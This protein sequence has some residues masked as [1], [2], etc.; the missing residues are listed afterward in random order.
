MAQ[1]SQLIFPRL[2]LEILYSQVNPDT[3]NIQGK[4]CRDDP[5]W[6]TDDNYMCKD[7]SI[8][9][10]TC[11]DVGKGQ[12]GSQTAEEACPVA[13]NT[14][15]KDVRIKRDFTKMYRRLPSPIKDA[16]E[17]N[18]SMILKDPEWAMGS[19]ITDV[20]RDPYLTDMIEELEDKVD[21]LRH[22]MSGLKCLCSDISGKDKTRKGQAASLAPIRCGNVSEQMEWDGVE[23]W[24]NVQS[25]DTDVRY[26][27]KCKKGKYQ[28]ANSFLKGKELV[29]NC[30][31]QTWEYRDE[32]HRDKPFVALDLKKYPDV[33]KCLGDTAH[34]AKPGK[35]H[36]PDPCV[37]TKLEAQPTGDKVCKTN[38][39]FTQRY[40]VGDKK[41]GWYLYNKGIPN[42]NYES[43]GVPTKYLDIVNKLKKDPIIYRPFTDKVLNPNTKKKNPDSK[44]KPYSDP[45]DD[46]KLP[47][48]GS[49]EVPLGSRL[50]VDFY[51]EIYEM[52]CVQE[53]PLNTF[54]V[55][56]LTAQSSVN[57]WLKVLFVYAAFTGIALGFSYVRETKDVFMVKA[58]S[59][60][61]IVPILIWFLYGSSHSDETSTDK[62]QTKL[63]IAWTAALVAA[64]SIYLM[65]RGYKIESKEFSSF[66]KKS[67]T[68]M[69]GFAGLSGIAGL[70]STFFP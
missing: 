37:C 9:G 70:T 32:G 45:F 67:G 46:S 13:C 29:Y 68:V 52:V 33:I 51:G 36:L 56:H 47:K 58:G 25:K 42:C 48:C 59:L 20:S 11:S 38:K 12:G 61:V 64:L 34:K 43:K 10:Y 30:T 6:K 65:L 3:G 49:K 1:P 22:S 55:Q 53:D 69:I 63:R 19:D 60:L 21:D 54:P 5:T 44:N 7:Y 27:V 31:N 8:G 62:G 24:T 66:T 14:C 28:D 35:S 4:I 40:T 16:P 26:K 2:D 50:K 57:D 39:T 18:Y 15:P 41:H 23:T 17:P